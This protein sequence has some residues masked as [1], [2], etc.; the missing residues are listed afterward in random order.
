MGGGLLSI[1][2]EKAV[3]IM[4]SPLASHLINI[5]VKDECHEKKGISTKN[6]IY[7]NLYR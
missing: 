3:W 2:S 5:E 6:M 4:R 1:G 7:K